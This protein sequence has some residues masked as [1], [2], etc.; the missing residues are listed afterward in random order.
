MLGTVGVSKRMFWNLP[1]TLATSLH[2]LNFNTGLVEQ[3]QY[4]PGRNSFPEARGWSSSP[5]SS[6]PALWFD[7][8]MYCL[9]SMYSCF[10]LYFHLLIPSV[11][12]KDVLEYLWSFSFCF[13][14]FLKLGSLEAEPERGILGA[15]DL[16]REGVPSEEREWGKQMEQQKKAKQGCIPDWKQLHLDPMR[17]FGAHIAP[18]SW[19]HLEARGLDF[20]TPI[21]VS[22]WLLHGITF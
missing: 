5:H 13:T 15:S 22:H 7:S 6:V 14:S 20:Y 8:V 10:Y 4:S 18:W 17:N 2:P 12:E 9:A 19:F 11:I 1:P 16:L 3:C 21:S